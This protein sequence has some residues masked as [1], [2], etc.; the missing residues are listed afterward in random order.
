MLLATWKRA[1]GQD[2]RETFDLQK[3]GP[4][5]VIE[6]HFPLGDT[7]MQPTA[8]LVVNGELLKVAPVQ[9]AP[10]ARVN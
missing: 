10:P 7:E 2:L 1:T 4:Y 3:L 5:A 9:D 8:R 6:M